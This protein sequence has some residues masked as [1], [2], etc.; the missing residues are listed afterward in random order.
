MNL[1]S[2][3]QNSFPDS[4]DDVLDRALVGE[5]ATHREQI[6]LVLR[7]GLLCAKDDPKSRPSMKE[8]VEYLQNVAHPLSSN[9]R[10]LEEL[11]IDS[12]VD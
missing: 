1:V 7:L 10:P 4:V 12:N 11:I 5:F 3:V 2:W 8:V 9:L 6:D